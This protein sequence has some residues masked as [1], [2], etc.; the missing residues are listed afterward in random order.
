MLDVDPLAELL[1]WVR[2]RWHAD[3]ACKEHP[4][5]NWF[6]ERGDQIKAEREVCA[7]CLV[8]SEC[9]AAGEYEMGVWGGLGVNARKKARPAVGQHVGPQRVTAERLKVIA[10]MR[11]R[12]ASSEAIAARL[13]I[14][15]GALNTLERRY[16]D[17][18]A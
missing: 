1:A 2:P 8:R 9:A 16:R 11:D 6:P 3:A 14:T 5:L 12:G 7:G 17:R 4:E 18:A 15:L 10:A 13:Q